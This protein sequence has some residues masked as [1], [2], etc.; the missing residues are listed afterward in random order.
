[1]IYLDHAAATPLAPDVL[2]AIQRYFTDKYFNASAGYIAAK[3]VAK[4]IEKARAKIAQVLGVRAAEII[5][6][7]GGTEANNLAIQ[8][9]MQAHS[10]S[11]LVVSSLEHD[12]ILEPARNYNHRELPALPSGVVSVNALKK[13]VDNQTVLVSIMYVNNEIGTIQPLREIAQ[14]LEEI[15]QERRKRGNKLPLY[16]H[17]DA[18]QAGNY[19]HLLA[20]K[21][22]VDLLTVNAGKLYGPKQSGALYV[23]AGTVLRPQI[24]GGGQEWNV[25]SGTESPAN[26]IGL[27]EALVSAQAIRLKESRRL[28]KLRQF[29]ITELEKNV[30]EARITTTYK[31]VIPNNV[32][33]SIP[34]YDNER[35]MMQLDE[36]GIICAVGSACSASS[37][38]PSHVLKAL[39]LSD[40]EARSSLRFTMGRLTTKKDITRTVKTLSK[41]VE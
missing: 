8:G 36:A 34:G 35:L 16:F 37:D 11:N 7:A 24:L 33:I 39:G 30:P 6:T 32:H 13:L 2:E 14:I 17:T 12:S 20:D 19:L 4:D 26:N 10:G 41:L 40:Q 15:K 31:H 21:L 38:E 28:E 22:G 29:F 18:C 25:R 23:K 1:M 5:F 3:E 9:V 27:A